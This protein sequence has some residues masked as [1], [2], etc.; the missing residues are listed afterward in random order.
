MRRQIHDRQSRSDVTVDSAYVSARRTALCLLSTLKAELGD[1]RKVRRVVK[2]FG[3]VNA[4]P[5]F[6]DHPRVIN[7]CSDLLVQVFGERGRHARSRGGHGIAAGEHPGGNRNGRGSGGRCA[8]HVLRSVDVQLLQ[9]RER[10]ADALQ[11]ILVVL[12][13]LAA[14]VHAKPLLVDEQL[15]AIE[16]VRERQ[17]ALRRSPARNIAHS[18]PSEMDWK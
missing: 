12:D 1:I 6:A 14:H 3:M 5:E 10:V 17:V 2:V 4:T 13:H 18:K 16:H 11:Q 9:Q 8:E 15:V 7:G